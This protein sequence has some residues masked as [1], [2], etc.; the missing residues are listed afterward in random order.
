MK[1]YFI[2]VAY[3]YKLHHLLLWTMLLGYWMQRIREFYPSLFET[4]LAA[5]IFLVFISTSVYITVYLLIPCFFN[6]KKIIRFVFYTVGIII[7][8]TALLVSAVEKFDAIF[9]NKDAPPFTFSNSF[10]PLLITV[11]LEVFFVVAIK[12][13][14]TRYHEQNYLE[15]LEKDRMEMEIKYLKAQMDPHFLLNSLN[16]IYYKI[17]KQNTEARDILMNFADMLKYQLYNSNMD[18]VSI[19]TELEYLKNYVDMQQVRLNKNYK[20]YFSCDENLKG[21]DV[22]PHLMLAFVENAFKH[23]SHFEDKQNEIKI[24]VKKINDELFLHVMN[25]KEESQLNEEQSGIGLANVQRRLKLLY[26]D[27][28]ELVINETSTLYEVNLK[29]QVS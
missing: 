7:L 5:L 1:P 8:S 27:E 4:F 21:F 25:T 13:L 15:L 29:I 28:H 6:K 22:V 16:T 26:P 10:F 18:K 24:D 9:A 17:D 3:K 11:I 12:L 20:V 2:S 23:V 14:L 19:E